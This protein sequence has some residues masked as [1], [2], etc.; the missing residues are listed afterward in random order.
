MSLNLI[1][2]S[3]VWVL[4]RLHP[5]HATNELLLLSELL[6]D[7]VALGSYS[8]KNPHHLEVQ[9]FVSFQLFEDVHRFLLELCVLGLSEVIQKVYILTILLV[10]TAARTIGANDVLSIEVEK[11]PFVFIKLHLMVDLRIH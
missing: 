2:Q 9:I 7:N 11:E 1:W 8:R 6:I 3:L 4:Q 5:L 10:F